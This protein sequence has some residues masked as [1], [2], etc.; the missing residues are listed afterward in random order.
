MCTGHSSSVASFAIAL[1][2]RVVARRTPRDALLLVLG[3]IFV[4]LVGDV[5]TGARLQ[6]SSAFGYSATVGIRV[7]GYGNVAYAMLGAAAILLS[8]LLAHR[9][10][11]RLG[12]LVAS[13]VMFVALIADIAPF[14]GGDV[15][16]V[17]SLVPAFGITA[18][19]LLGLRIRLSWRVVAIATSV[20]AIVLAVLTAFD[21]SRPPDSR[22]HL[23]RLA[24]QVLD[25]GITPFTD[26][27]H[28]KLD[29]NLATWSTSEWRIVLIPSVLFLCYLA[30][31]QRP[32]VRRM[33]T[34]IP[35]D[36][37]RVRGCGRA[38]AARIR[39]QR[40]WRDG[41]G[42]RAVGR[43]GVARACSS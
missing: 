14:W 20:T 27:I 42:R 43:V 10:G 25:E 3:V 36:A 1:A 16:G 41:P 26:T 29:A 35:A 34:E 9:I 21:L 15:G 2:A 38:R 31:R 12:A 4:V 33:F 23:G 40:Q 11:G 13:F 19:M 6:L 39:V 5:L 28:R 8:G 17:L 24:Q 30:L 37:R 32:L 22:T 18:A 7:A